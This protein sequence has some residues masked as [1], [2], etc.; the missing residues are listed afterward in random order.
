MHRAIL[1]SFVKEPEDRHVVNHI[2]GNKENNALSNLEWCTLSE[3]VQHALRILNVDY[4]K[5]SRKKVIA[6][7]KDGS[8]RIEFISISECA[9]FFNVATSQISRVLNG[10]RKTVH[11]YRILDSESC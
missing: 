8:N 5:S 3:N 11:G 1:K 6:E 4:A 7:K 9:K 2:D 10:R